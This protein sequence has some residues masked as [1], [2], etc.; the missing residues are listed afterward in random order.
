MGL[1]DRP[2][3]PPKTFLLERGELANT[4]DEVQP[5]FPAILSPGGKAVA[6]R[7]SSRC[8]TAPAAGWRW[9]SG[10]PAPDNPLTARVIV[11]RLWQ[12]HFGRG[13]RR[14][15]RATSASAANGRRTRS[16][17]T[18]WRRELVDAA[19]WQLEA[20]CTELMLLSET[21]QQSTHVDAEA[22]ARSDPDNQLLSRMNRLRLEGEA[23]RDSLLAVSGR[24]NPKVGGPG[25]VLP[26]PPAAGGRPR[27]V[28]VTADPKEHVRRSV[29]LFARRNLRLPVPGGVR[30]AR[31]QPELPEARAEHDRPAGAGAAERR[32]GD[33]RG[34]GA[35]RRG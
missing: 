28:P 22:A 16:C 32:R 29:Y 25:V 12:H 20:R 30:P 33:G 3:P 24:L 31:Q 27:P 15:A 18:G 13:H 5:G 2:G 17:S 14:D 11:N 19:S 7:R 1:T 8:P 9:R 34:E 10:S 4:G 6:G 35:G 21:Y 26:E 23:V